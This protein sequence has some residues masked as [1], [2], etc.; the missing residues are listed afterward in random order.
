MWMSSSARENVS[1][2]ASISA[3]TRLSPSAIAATSSG[4]R[5]PASPSIATCASEPRTSWGARRL[6][7][8]ID[9]LISSMISAGPLANRPPH[10]RLLMTS[11]PSAPPPDA[12][13]APAARRI[14][15]RAGLALA[16]VALGVLA[17]GAALYGAVPWGNRACAAA[18]E[19][20]RRAAPLARGEVAAFEVDATLG[21][22]PDAAFTGPEG[23]RLTLA[24]LRGRTVLVNLWATWC[25]PCKAEMPALD[26][27]QARLGGADFAVV[28][29]NLDTRNLD[30]ARGWLRDNGIAHLAYY[31]DPAGRL[32]PAL[33][34]SGEVAGLPTT[35]VID[36]AGCEVGVMK[37]PADWASEDALK[38][39]RAL[40]G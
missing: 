26:R 20:G 18:R 14:R 22:A 32:L 15:R 16:G 1:V 27:L 13:P 5:M 35:I 38:L 29:V 9:A 10:I 36:R 37:G 39:V 40:I 4:G 7:K 23:Q 12:A 2:P 19:A 33:Q 24:D 3:P 31:A 25:A 11:D 34:R 30:R 21:P 8:S 6:S 17:A 28:A